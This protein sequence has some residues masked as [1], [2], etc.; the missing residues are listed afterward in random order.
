M[1]HRL[2]VLISPAL[3][4][5]LTKAAQRSKVSKGEWVRRALEQTLRGHPT[6]GR[7]VAPLTRLEALGGPT[8]DIDRMLGEI[9]AGRS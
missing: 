7:P 6:G 9:E 4:A 1:S 3:D 2:Q 8:G 5:Q